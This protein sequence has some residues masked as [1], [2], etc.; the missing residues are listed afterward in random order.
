MRANGIA[1]PFSVWGNFS[2]GSTLIEFDRQMYVRFVRACAG[3][4]E[5]GLVY[6]AIGEDSCFLTRF[7]SAH[8]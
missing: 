6:M 7:N 2:V 4:C 3:K 1:D 8:I 5:S